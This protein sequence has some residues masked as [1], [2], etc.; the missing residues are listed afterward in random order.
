[1]KKMVSHINLVKLGLGSEAVLNCNSWRPVASGC[2]SSLATYCS[3]CESGI[4]AR[5]ICRDVVIRQKTQS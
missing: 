5:E 3:K 2:R 1:M 4:V